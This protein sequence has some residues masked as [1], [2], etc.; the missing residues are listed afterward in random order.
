MGGVMMRLRL[1]HWHELSYDEKMFVRILLMITGIP[2]TI[3]GGATLLV[4]SLRQLGP[5][6]TIAI[7]FGIVLCGAV[8][9][10]V[11]WRDPED[12]D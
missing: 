7:I 3:I 8:V 9:P 12:E 11:T 5:L 4:L 10:F 6:Y 2:A 1:K